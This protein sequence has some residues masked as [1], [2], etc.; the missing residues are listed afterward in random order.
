MSFRLSRRSLLKSVSLAALLLPF[1]VFSDAS[2]AKKDTLEVI[3][4]RKELRVGLDPGFIPFEMKKP[5]GE[6][7]GFD[8]DMVTAFAAELGAKPVIVDTKWEGIIPSLQARKFDVIVSGMTITEERKKAIAFSDPYYKA[9][10]AMLYS[11]KHAGK[12]KKPEDFN[13][14]GMTVVVKLGTTADF[15]ADKNFK[16]AKVVKL[17]AESDCS[18]SVLLGKVDAF[19]YDKPYLELFAR[20]NS[21]KVSAFLEPMTNEDFGLA[22]RKSDT[23]LIAAFNDFLKRW[24]QSGDYDKAIKT[25]FVDMPWIKDFPDL[26]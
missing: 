15:F 14:A 4:V 7:V 17:D 24:R 2:A 5:S 11:N 25:H 19:L 26:K 1:A 10:L 12:V 6:W 8:I 21:A 9:G 3:K 23:K 16:N 22:A 20:K 18:N 13:K